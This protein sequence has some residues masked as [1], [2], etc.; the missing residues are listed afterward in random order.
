MSQSF[1]SGAHKNSEEKECDSEFWRF[2]GE[3]P[4][5]AAD[6]LEITINCGSE[7]KGQ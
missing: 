3:P 4:Q 2:S 6:S 7:T 5:A 1:R